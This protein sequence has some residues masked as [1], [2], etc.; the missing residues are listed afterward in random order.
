MM[1]GQMTA[2]VDLYRLAGHR[3]GHLRN[4]RRSRAPA[5]RRRLAGRWILTAG[6]GG[7]GGAQ[8]LAANS[9]APALSP[10]SASRAVSRS[11][12]KPLS[13]RPRPRTRRGARAHQRTAC[14]EERRSRSGCCGNAAEISRRSYAAYVAAGGTR[15]DLVTDQTSAHDPL[16]GYLPAGWTCMIGTR[17]SRNL[18]HRSRGAKPGELAV[19]VRA[20]LDF[21]AM[22]IP[23]VDYGNNIRQVAFDAGVANAFDS[24]ALS[25]LYPSAVLPRQR[26]VPLGGAFRRSGRHLP[27][28]CEHEGAVPENGTCIAGW[29]WRA[30]ANRIPGIAR[31]ASAGSASA[32]ATG[33]VSPSNEM[34]ASGELRAPM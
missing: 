2:G 4:L 22:G 10:S 17:A 13:R 34:V 24:R 21:H 30:N 9:R 18:A 23:A 32:N 31:R 16:N 26:P 1:Y 7:M 28:R 27:D 12:L 3:S 14:A 29:T 20:M 25:G 19:H 8:P 11:A 33:S 6:L 5:L 15:P